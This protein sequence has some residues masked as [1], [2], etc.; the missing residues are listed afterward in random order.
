MSQSTIVKKSKLNV[1]LDISKDSPSISKRTLPKLPPTKADKRPASNRG[2]SAYVNPSRNRKSMGTFSG[3]EDNSNILERAMLLANSSLSGLRDIKEL[4]ERNRD[5]LTK[6]ITQLEQELKE[7]KLIIEKLETVYNGGKDNFQKILDDKTTQ[8]QELTEEINMMKAMADKPKVGE[9]QRLR[10]ELMK[11]KKLYATESNQKAKLYKTKLRLMLMQLEALKRSY[12][13]IVINMSTLKHEFKIQWSKLRDK[14]KKRLHRYEPLIAELKKENANLRKKLISSKA[15][16]DP[17]QKLQTKYDEIRK[18]LKLNPKDV[19][20]EEYKEKLAEAKERVS[21]LEKELDEKSYMEIQWEQEVERWKEA[22]SEIVSNRQKA[23]EK[24]KEIKENIGEKLKE[25]R[26]KTDD[27]I[28]TL[29]QTV[30]E[31]S[32]HFYLSISGL[33]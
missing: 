18:R 29:N 12:N 14:V 10:V 22:F 23:E 20:G 17:L 5:K 33:K 1:P 27:K 11:L 19:K 7:K 4:D 30:E 16:S 26:K 6:R 15:Y 9:V 32:K 24:W 31:L 2:S 3:S 13:S 25:D 28:I 21:Q 8:I